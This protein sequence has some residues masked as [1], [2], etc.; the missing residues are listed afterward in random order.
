MNAVYYMEFCDILREMGVN[1][2]GIRSAGISLMLRVSVG[3]TENL[4]R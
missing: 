4:D 1:V 2:R 3:K